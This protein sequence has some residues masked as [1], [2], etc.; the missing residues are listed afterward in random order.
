MKVATGKVVGGKIV[1]GGEPWAEGTD[2]ERALLETESRMVCEQDEWP[3]TLRNRCRQRR[4]RDPR[5]QPGR[6]SPSRPPDADQSC[7]C[8]PHRDRLAVRAWRGLGRGRCRRETSFARGDG[9]DA[10]SDRLS[11]EEEGFAN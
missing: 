3:A 4:G 11:G 1:I 10:F 6:K 5:S 7:E 8:E 9:E 2:E